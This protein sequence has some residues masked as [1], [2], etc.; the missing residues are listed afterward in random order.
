MCRVLFLPETPYIRFVFLLFLSCR[1][2][3]GGTNFVHRELLW[4][5]GY[6]RVHRIIRTK[7][8]H[9][10]PD[11]VRAALRRHALLYIAS[12]TPAVAPKRHPR[13]RITKKAVPAATPAAVKTEAKPAKK[14]PKQKKAPAS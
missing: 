8:V 6:R 10:R 11:L 4:K 12:H 9:Y 13:H 14:A 7:V 1:L 5:G 2:A 3:L